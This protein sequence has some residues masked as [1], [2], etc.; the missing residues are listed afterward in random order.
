MC[1]LFK[2][3]AFAAVILI[4]SFIKAYDFTSG[5]IYYN[6]K[7]NEAVVTY[8]NSTSPS[9]TSPSSYTGNIIIPQTVVYDNTTY[10]ITAVDE[11]A[12]LY[13]SISSVTF[14]EGIK[15]IGKQA[16]SNCNNLTSITLPNSVT[17]I[18]FDAF[19]YN[20]SLSTVTIGNGLA[21]VE[22]GGFYSSAV[23]NVYI[24]GTTPPIVSNYLFSSNPVV[25]VKANAKSDFEQSSWTSFGI[26]EIYYDADYDYTD[27]CEIISL[28]ENKSYQDG[29]M[30]GQYSV[31]S[32]K[33]FNNAIG[34][35]KS[36]SVTSTL[37][38]IKTAAKEI[39]L[40]LPSLNEI[41]QGYYRIVSAGNGQGYSDGP[42]IYEYN[43]SLYNNNGIVRWSA[44]SANDYSMIYRLEP[45]GNDWSV[46]NLCDKSY[47]QC[48]TASFNCN[49]TT[50]PVPSPQTFTLFE[51]GKYI[52]QAKNANNVYAMTHSHNG[53]SAQSGTLDVWGTAT[54]AVKYG[55]NLWYLEPVSEEIVEFLKENRQDNSFIISEEPAEPKANRNYII[56][57]AT[58]NLYLNSEGALT[59][60]YATNSSYLWQIEETGETVDTYPTFFLKSVSLDKYWKQIDYASKKW[61]SNAPYD[62][63]DWYDYA[64][65]NGEF[66]GVD[67]AMEV[68]I[69]PAGTTDS[70]RSDGATNGYVIAMKDIVTTDKNY[71]Y[72]LGAQDNNVGMEPWNENIGWLFYPII[73][74]ENAKEDIDGAL[75]MYG[76]LNIEGQVSDSPGFH[77]KQK[78]EIY[79]EALK[80]TEELTGTETEETIRK[81]ISDLKSAYEDAKELNPIKEGY[82]YIVTAGNG[83]GYNN[84]YY[85]YEWKSALYNDGEYVKWKPF[86][87]QDYEQI[88]YFSYA[89]NNTWNVCS[90]Q[91]Q[92]YINK[93]AKSY[94][95]KISTSL[96]PETT[97]SFTLITK[98]K[99]AIN[100]T[101]NPYVYAVE[102]SHNG[103][104]NDTGYLNIWGTP[105][106]ASKYG[107]NMW[108]IKTVPDSILEEF[109]K[110]DMGLLALCS[111]YE[112]I[113]NNLKTGNTPGLYIEEN[114]NNLKNVIST[115][116][117]K[118][119]A[120]PTEEEKKQIKQELE[121]AYAKA[122]I[123]VPVTD[124]YY[125]IINNYEDYKKAYANYASIYTAP[126]FIVDNQSSAC[127]YETFNKDNPHFIYKI[128]PTDNPN[129]F[130]IENAY[131][132]WFLNTGT[133]SNEPNAIKTCTEKNLTPQIIT[134]S[135]A[136][137]FWIADT[138]NSHHAQSLSYPEALNKRNF[139]VAGADFSVNQNS[140][141]KGY[142]T[143]SL[144]P[145]SA[146]EV[147]DLINKRQET[148]KTISVA[149]DSMKTFSQSIEGKYALIVNDTEGEYNSDAVIA[150][151]SKQ[152][153][154]SNY[155]K[156]RTYD[157]VSTAQDYLDATTE[158]KEAL[159]IALT[160]K[161]DSTAQ[162]KLIGTPIGAVSVDYSTNQ[163]SSSV[164][165]PAEVFDNDYTTIYAAYE[166]STGYVGLDLGKKYVIN[167]IAYAPRSNWA[168]RMVLGV[169]EGANK[170]DFS[171]AI[172][173]Y[174]IKEEPA[175]DKMTYATINCSRGFR[176]V[177]YVGPNDARCNISELR[178]YGKEGEG[179][180]S[181][182]Y[183]L[184]NLPLIVIRTEA[185]IS[186]VTSKTT[187]L[188]GHVN[189]IS[190]NGTAFKTDSMNVRGRGNGSWTFE[191]KPYKLKLANKTRLLGMPAN[192][193]EWTL[194]NNY[195]DKTMIRNNVA[196]KL[197]EIFEMDYTPACT[198]VDVV[199]NGQYKGSY[200][201]CD[202][203]EVRKNRVD[204]TEMTPED[205]SGENLTGGYLIEIDAYAGSEPKHFTSAKYNIP[206]TVHYP[207]NEDITTQ[208]F[209]Y[210]Q[211]AFNELCESVYSD[212]YKSEL[213]GYSNYLDEN[214]W[215]KYFLIE[216]LSG[217]TD[218]Y[219][220]VYLTKDRNDKFRVSPVWDFDLAFDNDRRT[221]PILTMTDFLSLSTKS[222]AANGVRNFNRK[223]VES[224][225]KELKELWSWYRYRGNLNYEYLKACVDSLG[226]ENSLSQEYNY[227]RWPILN[228]CTQQ[229]YTTR[230]SYKAEVDFINEY[231]YD[232]LAWL[233]NKV[234]LEEPIGIHNTI[235]NKAIGG[236]HGHEG[237]ILVRGFCENSTVK[238]YTVDGQLKQNNIIT[239]FQNRFDLPKGVY[240]IKVI[241]PQ[242]KTMSKK[243]VVS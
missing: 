205:N 94:S 239:D 78:V 181:R 214:S 79:K 110:I 155:I 196:F 58:N 165:T 46:F 200:Q 68:T 18:G 216:E 93:G 237:Y 174:I 87:P 125:Y 180:D 227:I 137:Q 129:Q 50:T 101:G 66:S 28:Y 85:N 172:P 207:D 27:L 210:I 209:Q 45:M 61:E 54:E 81:T 130:S 193:K 241:S 185:N 67:N 100:F 164:N 218:G 136:G 91:K 197:S 222:S 188:P 10:E 104:E 146:K 178:F 15:T 43:I 228:V 42:Y 5:G 115:S 105:S 12:F 121:D 3:F 176:Y 191:K 116:R 39:L 202:Q 89:E 179:D 31:A 113:A 63:F 96:Q 76:H 229:Q 235:D 24:N 51:N 75:E 226:E 168:G 238:I 122:K 98:G 32:I 7:N 16:F 56:K 108:Y 240:I 2:H 142:D 107:V 60:E 119:N 6:I 123:T 80:K 212:F 134:W 126:K 149:F 99:F 52:I 219:W 35:A 160:T 162:Q 171:D 72:K 97:Q 124:G 157:I 8:P 243:I 102:A 145:I 206:V 169:F 40:N 173:F 33:N 34:H 17:N 36:L 154:V 73:S 29:N 163:Q 21:K 195:G 37:A 141:A 148:D 103:S 48:G 69:L 112:H 90:A 128:T 220:S 143:W 211:K 84:S 106:E 199:F 47:I 234:G 186:E 22:Q 55:V 224:C 170:P 217:N 65:L 127:Y 140:N 20:S 233:D 86:N 4:P 159:E 95:T 198:L 135:S 183:Q 13:S 175:Y 49:V 203:I 158:L 26:F 120:Q 201:L 25:Y 41:S 70:W 151:V 153:I 184:T 38:E 182:L 187:W 64:G 138:L 9:N 242:G 208:Q 44:Y 14:S 147:E 132:K 82:Y 11:K 83:P 133:I 139:V 230:G 109:Y 77:D 161:P 152:K 213:G 189:I 131:T 92:T 111:N 150:L 19:A 156:T 74:N 118:I 117:E 114:V 30:P 231:L 177:R 1:N 215:L 223:I 194:I 167:K 23:K 204:I 59:E 236:I 71:F 221:H 225:S 62:A 232:R 190:D 144:I 166:R 57:N 192:A 53:T 88:Y